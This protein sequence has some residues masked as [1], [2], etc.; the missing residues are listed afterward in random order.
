MEGEREVNY[1]FAKIA[2]TDIIASL[3]KAHTHEEVFELFKTDHPRLMVIFKSSYN[4][5]MNIIHNSV[6][7]WT[8]RNQSNF[9][10]FTIN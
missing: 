2:N 10:L 4:S 9:K 5:R 8:G 1:F 3:Y 6:V 7:V